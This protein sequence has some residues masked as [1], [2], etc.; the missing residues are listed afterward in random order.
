MK[1]RATRAPPDSSKQLVLG[2][3]TDG[4]AHRCLKTQEFLNQPA[5]KLLPAK[6]TG[7]FA[8][9]LSESTGELRRTRRIEAEILNQ[10]LCS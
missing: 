9:S 5:I 2:T 1:I 8:I 7:K 4:F 6:L 3:L 10:T